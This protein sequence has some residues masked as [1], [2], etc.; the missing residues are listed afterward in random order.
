MSGLGLGCHE[1]D[2]MLCKVRVVFTGIALD[3]VGAVR[4]VR[5][6]ADVFVLILRNVVD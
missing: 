6:H 3:T 1:V 5:S 2:D 4:S